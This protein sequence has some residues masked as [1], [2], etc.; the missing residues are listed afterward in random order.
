MAFL[1]APGTCWPV[2]VKSSFQVC[3][4]TGEGLI[5]PHHPLTLKGLPTSRI[6]ATPL[7]AG[8]PTLTV[9]TNNSEFVL[10]L[11]LSLCPLTTMTQEETYLTPVV[12]P[13]RKVECALNIESGE[14]LIQ[15]IGCIS[16]GTAKKPARDSEAGHR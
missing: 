9:W 8:S 14:N 10:V 1:Q 6:I 15:G 12:G 4:P 16:D 13:N 5:M 11:C 7:H 3:P 2:E